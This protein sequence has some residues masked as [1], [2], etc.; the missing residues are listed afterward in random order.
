MEDLLGTQQIDHGNFS[1]HQ[2][3]LN[4]TK[5]SFKTFFAKLA[6]EKIY[7]AAKFQNSGVVKATQP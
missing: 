3:V 2:T 7:K 5:E 4:T 6:N 1:Y